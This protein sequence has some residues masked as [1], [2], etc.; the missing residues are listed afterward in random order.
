[1]FME[2]TSPLDAF[3]IFL[4]MRK[5]A[6]GEAFQTV[7]FQKSGDILRR[8]VTLIQATLYQSVVLF[9][10]SSL[11]TNSNVPFFHQFLMASYEESRDA[12]SV[13]SGFSILKLYSSN[14]NAH[15]VFRHLPKTIQAYSSLLPSQKDGLIAKE[16]V[17]NETR[18]WLDAITEIIEQGLQMI[19]ANI[20]TGQSLA[21]LSREITFTVNL[22]EDSHINP[23]NNPETWRVSLPTWKLLCDMLD[24]KDFSI[25]NNYLRKPFHDFSVVLMTSSLEPIYALSQQITNDPRFHSGEE[26]LFCGRFARAIALR[27]RQL[28]HLFVTDLMFG[29]G[30]SMKAKHVQDSQDQK[31]RIV[32]KKFMDVYF[33]AHSLWVDGTLER[34]AESL[35]RELKNSEWK[36]YSNL[37]GLCEAHTP[38][39][40]AEL[41]ESELPI[42][43]KMSRFL[44]LANLHAIGDLSLEKK[45]AQRLPKIYSEVFSQFSQDELDEKYLIQ[46]YF[47]I[48]LLWKIL[49]GARTGFDSQKL[50]DLKEESMTWN[51][52]LTFVKSKIDPV[53]LTILEPH[54]QIFVDKYCSRVMILYG[55]CIINNSRLIEQTRKLPHSEK[56]APFSVL[57]NL[58]RFA[59]LPT[60]G[61]NSEKKVLQQSHCRQEQSLTPSLMVWL[62]WSVQPRQQPTKHRTPN[63]TLVPLKNLLLEAQA[64]F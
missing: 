26:R 7:K 45:L 35:Q 33:A 17:M 44:S 43:A 31:I 36:H 52:L 29:A 38:D 37:I 22:E 50:E 59:L 8:L 34:F 3:Q 18:M 64:L 27:M 14:T 5:E 55:S 2:K 56:T 25:W 16:V 30:S 42:P 12:G 13:G 47:D 48:K 1:M 60:T 6:I 9:L 4:S 53:S 39:D 54:L 10:D 51:Q 24:F 46:A 63:G 21:D 62:D 11:A 58:P 15:T 32:E 61:L 28:S 23:M 57:V 49:E 19:F 20:K 40:G 41:T